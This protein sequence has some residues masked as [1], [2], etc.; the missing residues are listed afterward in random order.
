MHNI[1]YV[2]KYVQYR[3]IK[4]LSMPVSL[5]KQFM[6]AN[7]NTITLLQLILPVFV[8]VITDQTRVMAENMLNY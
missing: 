5:C 4:I 2:K 3:L 1:T 6:K 8:I 7:A